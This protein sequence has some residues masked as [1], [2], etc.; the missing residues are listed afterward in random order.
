MDSENS[1][2]KV[3]GL[4]KYF[5]INKGHQTLYV[6][7]IDG[8]DFTMR[9]GETFGLVGESGSGKS[10]TAYCIIGMYG[11]SDGK[12]VYKGQ[13]ICKDTYHRS[14]ELRRDVQIVF[15]DPGTSLNPQRSIAQILELP[16]RVHGLLEGQ[17]REEKLIRLLES[18]ELPESYLYKYPRLIGGGERQMVAIARALATDPSFVILDEPTSSLDVSV[19]AK[20]INTLMRLQKEHNLSYLFITHDLSLMRNMA[21]RVAIMYLGKIAELAPTAQFFRDPKH[22]YTQMLLSSIPVV[23]TE[24]E[25]LKPKRIKSQGEIPSPVNV[26][27]GCSFQTRCPLAIPV[28]KEQDPI[29]VQVGPDHYA[30]CHLLT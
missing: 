30:R 26:P 22:P 18:V 16:M 25:E 7:A 23:S 5:P 21:T 6:K 1:I 2:L 17:D 20:I 15:Q 8:I 10:T 27:P 13:D 28:C 9:P 19:Q 12:I 24:E 29:M 4:K 3:T 11:I 14:R